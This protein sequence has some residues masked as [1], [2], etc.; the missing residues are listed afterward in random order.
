ME[1]LPSQVDKLHT[2]IK[3]LLLLPGCGSL[4]WEVVQDPADAATGH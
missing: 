3:V 2:T 4:T 1:I